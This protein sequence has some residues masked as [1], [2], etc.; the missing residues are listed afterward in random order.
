M[1]LSEIREIL[2]KQAIQ[3]KERICQK[4]AKDLRPVIDVYRGGEPVATIRITAAGGGQTLATVYGMAVTGFDADQSAYMMD[5]YSNGPNLDPPDINPLTGEEL[6]ATGLSTLFLHHD[7]GAK[8]WV[9]ECLIIHVANK[10]GDFL[11]TRLPY[12]YAVNGRYL[13][14]DEPWVSPENVVGEAVGPV[15]ESVARAMND[16]PSFSQVFP[17]LAA[18]DV[19]RAE[20]D[21]AVVNV[22]QSV[23]DCQVILWAHQGGDRERTIRTRMRSR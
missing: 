6:D 22:I 10:A 13:V 8:G 2:V 20:L 18:T 5:G 7:G 19:S 23:V 15:A 1:L 3:G 11:L 12:H 17:G 9:S 21:V 14:W 4:G 16:T